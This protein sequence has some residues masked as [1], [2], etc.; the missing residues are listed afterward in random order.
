M[1]LPPWSSTTLPVQSIYS[2]PLSADKQRW[3][4]FALESM[5]DLRLSPAEQAT[6]H[7]AGTVRQQ[8]DN[9]NYFR[10][11]VRPDEIFFRYDLT[12][13]REVLDSFLKLAASATSK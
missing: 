3:K 5:H 8:P 6:C 10:R 4:L 13:A 9:Y 12:G 11:A 1:S 7:V 2:H